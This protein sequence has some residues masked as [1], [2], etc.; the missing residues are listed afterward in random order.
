MHK[1]VEFRWRGRTWR[2]LLAVTWCTIV[3]GQ[4]AYASTSFRLAREGYSSTSKTLLI[5]AR[6]DTGDPPKSPWLVMYNAATG[7]VERLAIPQNSAPCT[8]AWAPG[9]TAFIVTH[10]EGMT[11]FQKDASCHGYAPTAIRCPTGFLYTHCSWSPKGE[12]FAVNCVDRENITRGRLGLYSLESKKFVRTRLDIDHREVL[13]R[14]DGLLHAT[15]NDK[16][17]AVR[18]EGGKPVV[19]RSMPL[20]G[21]LTLFYGMFGGQPLFQAFDEIRLG[22]RTLTALDRPVKFRVIATETTAFIAA[23]STQLVAFDQ[24][25]HEIARINP[26]KAIV[27][28]SLGEDPNTVYGLADSVLLRISVKDRSLKIQEICDLAKKLKEESISHGSSQK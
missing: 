23:S 8:F 20:E 3:V 9:R 6:D 11:L 21:E 2:L 16:V 14:S 1:K 13:W 5:V 10:Y 18:L 26:A 24:E 28:G 17:L 7:S 25:G 19:V 12:W 22:N 15:D 27:L 4:R